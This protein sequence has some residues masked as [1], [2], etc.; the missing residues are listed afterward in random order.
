MIHTKSGVNISRLGIGTYLGHLNSETDRQITATIQAAVKAA[1]NHIDTAPN[2]RAQRSELAIGTALNALKIE[3]EKIFISS[4]VG[5]VPFE[6]EV[7]KNDNAYFKNRFLD[8]KIFTPEELIGGVQ[9]FTPKYI[10]WQV[11]E[12]LERLSTNYLDLVYLHNFENILSNVAEKKVEFI[13]RS[14]LSSLR[15][16]NIEGKIRMIGMASW[17]GFLLS[18]QNSLH[19]EKLK[20][21]AEKEDCSDIFRV[22]QAPFNLGFPHL[23]FN[24]S[25]NVNG[26]EISLIRAAHTLNLSL[27]TSAPLMH[28]R[29][30]D[31][32]LPKK[33]KDKWPNLTVS[34]ICIAIAKSAPTIVSTLVGVKSNIHLEELL[35]VDQ[36]ETLTSNE[37]I[38]LLKNNV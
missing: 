32:E 23:L 1:I 9:C 6:W 33:L 14:A 35:E 34:Q 24:K 25:Q 3:R 26:K 38:D 17:G 22:I 13:F 2:Y 18:E 30:A 5:F 19:L 31:L 21:W 16:L 11:N 8:S 10:H 36:L 15:K 7:P 27:I 29:L 12:S 20:F 28:G 37:F 4:K